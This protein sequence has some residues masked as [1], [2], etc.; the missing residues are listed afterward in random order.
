MK[1]LLG[2]QGDNRITSKWPKFNIYLVYTA[3][4]IDNPVCKF[5]KC[6]CV[7]Y[8]QKG[9]LGHCKLDKIYISNECDTILLLST[10][11]AHGDK[12]HEK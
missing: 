5:N 4:I 6:H 9:C 2:V 3:L 11:R 8:S 7:C 10:T 1:L 12:N